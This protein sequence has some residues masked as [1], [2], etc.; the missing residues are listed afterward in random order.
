MEPA[1][2]LAFMTNAALVTPWI[3]PAHL[4][5]PRSALR[6][7]SVVTIIGMAIV[8]MGRKTCAAGVEAE[9]RALKVNARTTNARLE[10]RSMHRVRRASLTFVRMMRMAAPTAGIAMVSMAQESCAIHVEAL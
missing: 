9:R 1:A 10:T 7:P 6:T 2:V 5:L 8:S 4:A 3:L